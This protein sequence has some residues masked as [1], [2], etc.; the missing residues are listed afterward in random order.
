VKTVRFTHVVQR[1]GKPYVH[2]LWVSPEKDSEFARARKECRVMTIHSG[3]GKAEFG[4]VGFE[5]DRPAGSQFL[6]FPRPLKPFEDRRV[7]GIKFDQVAQPDVVAATAYPPRT[8]TAKARSRAAGAPAVARDDLKK[9]AYASPRRTKPAEAETSARP[10]PVETS[11]AAAERDAGAS[12]AR[13]PA[14]ATPAAGPTKASR[15]AGPTRG[16]EQRKAGEQVGGAV[17]QNFLREIRSAV[18]ELDADKPMAAHRRL[19]RLLRQ[20]DNANL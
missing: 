12:T 6:V 20:A 10:N 7:I 1:S 18:K 8:G 13:R 9:S 17:L 11:E 14:R 15:G 16:P 19:E 5:A 3:G 4:V 2:T